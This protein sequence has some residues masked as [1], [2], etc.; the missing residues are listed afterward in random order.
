MVRRGV[1][2][3][4]ALVSLL[5]VADPTAAAEAGP[6]SPVLS[7]NARIEDALPWLDEHH[8]LDSGCVTLEDPDDDPPCYPG[9]TKWTALAVAHAGVDPGSWPS[10]QASLLGWLLDHAD[11]LRDTEYQRCEGEAVESGVCKQRRTFSLAK[12]VLAFRAAGEDPRSIPLSDGGERDFV[13]DL[14]DT[15]HGGQFG[16]HEYIN[17]DIWALIALHSVSYD[18]SEV[19]ATADTLEKHQKSNGGF[20]YTGS[21]SASSDTTGAAIMALAPLDREEPVDAAL[22]F[23]RDTQVQEGDDRACWSRQEGGSATAGSTAW[24]MQGLTAAGVD[25]LTWAVADQ[26]P[27]ACL[28]GFQTAQ[29][30]YANSHRDGQDATS[31]QATYQAMAA[32]GWAPYGTVAQPSTPTTFEQDATEGEETTIRMPEGVLRVDGQPRTSYD[33]TPEQTGTRVF[34]GATWEPHPRPADLVVHVEESSSRAGGSGGG[35]S[36]GETTPPS[37]DLPTRIEAERNV[38]RSIT[39][40]A[41]PTDDPVVELKVDWG[42]G[43]A[44]NWQ[45]SADFAHTYTSLGEHP[46][47]AWAR[48]ADGDVARSSTTVEVVDAAPTI[49]IDGPSSV[50][51][52]EPANLTAT[53]QDPDGPTP[54]VRWATGDRTADGLEASFRFEAA[55]EHR[56][57]AVATDQAGNKADATHTIEALNRAPDQPQVRPAEVPAN[58]T[59]VLRANASDP[60]GDRLAF[61]WTPP[62]AAEPSA[63]GSQLHL[64]TG[65]PGT[66]ELT[67]NASDGRGGWTSVRVEVT[68]TETRDEGSDEAAERVETSSSGQPPTDEPDPPRAPSPEPPTVELPGSLSVRSDRTTLLSGMAHDPDGTV[69]RVVV[70][71]GGRLP[72]Q[73]ASDFIARVPALPPGNYTLQAYAIDRAGH[74]GPPANLTLEV[75]APPA[76]EPVSATG[77]PEPADVPAPTGVALIALVGAGLAARRLR[78]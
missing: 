73:G 37:V 71:L 44:T 16:G 46:L 25:P 60:D 72:V 13:S 77:G 51:R 2:V 30:G 64:E 24:A 74:A 41:T 4:V 29:G 66:V 22:G 11:D 39:I 65:S 69:D 54:E 27:T 75:H 19:P 32:L 26:G 9:S 76:D 45:A 17:D 70:E 58:E 23:L 1:L 52:T 55:G 62:G 33:W 48:D 42:D 7:P 56:I 47:T 63:W 5:G 78:L 34:Q 15:Y 18:G 61:A 40:D 3:A 38:S 31:F 28:A 12:A 6:R 68:V 43:D 21:V 8:V 50:N 53:A 67:V 49:E 36:S 35:A 10:E 59:V 14:L 57:E 20:G